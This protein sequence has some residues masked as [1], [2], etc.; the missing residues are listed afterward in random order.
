MHTATLRSGLRERN[1][2]EKVRR[3]KQAASELFIEKGF[4]DATTREIAARADVGMGTLFLYADNKRDLLFLIANDELAAIIDK[5]VGAFRTDKSV[6]KSL[7]GA[8]API[9]TYF[10]TQPALSR[11]TLREMTFYDSGRQAKRFHASRERLIG[12][13]TRIIEAGQ[14]RGDITRA[15]RAEFIG[16]IAFCIYQVELRRWL[17]SEKP[18]LTSGIKRLERALKLYLAGAGTSKPGHVAG[19]H[20]GKRRRQITPVT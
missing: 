7:I 11:I 15:E 12:L 17:T 18:D 16:W 20:P 5:A 3:I 4:D 9:Y 14:G 1:K 8:F 19:N 13:L 2:L 10:G 6:L